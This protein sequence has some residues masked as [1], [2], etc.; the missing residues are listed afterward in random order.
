M[1]NKVTVTKENI[2]LKRE[3]H[4]KFTHEPLNSLLNPSLS[5]SSLF[6]VYEHFLFVYRRILIGS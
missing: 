4:M 1:K 5:T 6:I 3:L 2:K